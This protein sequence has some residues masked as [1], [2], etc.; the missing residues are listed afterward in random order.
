LGR[1]FGH[2]F[3]S[4]GVGGKL[5]YSCP[6]KQVVFGISAGVP[7]SIEKACP[8]HLKVASTSNFLIDYEKYAPSPIFGSILVANEWPAKESLL[9]ELDQ[10]LP[11][12]TGYEALFHTL[13]ECID[14]EFK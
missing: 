13:R 3:A 14:Q 6:E 4:F 9:C 7:A 12:L 2:C 5:L 8:G 10:L 1:L 11:Y